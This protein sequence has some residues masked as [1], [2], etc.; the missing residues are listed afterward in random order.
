MVSDYSTVCGLV[1]HHLTV[2]TGWLLPLYRSQWLSMLTVDQRM[3][4]GYIATCG[5]IPD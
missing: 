4:T 3:D 2:S 1:S 5:A